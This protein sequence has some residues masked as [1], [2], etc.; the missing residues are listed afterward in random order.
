MRNVSNIQ[1][2]PQ[3]RIRLSNSIRCLTQD[4]CEWD[5]LDYS[6]LHDPVKQAI[7]PLDQNTRDAFYKHRE[8]LANLL[9]QHQLLLTLLNATSDN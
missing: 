4:M 9:A 5:E 2:L 3:A 6:I 1:T 7:Y 8:R